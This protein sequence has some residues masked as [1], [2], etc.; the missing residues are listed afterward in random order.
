MVSGLFAD[1]WLWFVEILFV[2]WCTSW[3]AYLIVVRFVLWGF[4]VWVDFGRLLYTLFIMFIRVF[5][6]ITF[7]CIGWFCLGG[8]CLS[9]WLGFGW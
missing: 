2:D 3:G 7:S 6:I 1:C 9:V 8:F 5:F 4:G